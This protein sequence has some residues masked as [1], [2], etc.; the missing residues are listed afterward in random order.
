MKKIIKRV[1]VLYLILSCF[2]SNIYAKTI[3]QGNFAYIV[4]DKNEIITGF[5]Q[6]DNKL[7]YC[8][9]TGILTYTFELGK[10]LVDPYIRAVYLAEQCY[11][12]N[13]VKYSQDQR[14]FGLNFDCSS[15]IGRFKLL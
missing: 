4:N 12:S 11:D 3:I 10:E 15:F 14:A 2:I 5:Y 1:L 7:Y 13:L 9:P 8:S 6:E